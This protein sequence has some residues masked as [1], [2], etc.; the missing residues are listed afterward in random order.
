MVIRRVVQFLLPTGP[1]ALGRTVAIDGAGESIEVRPDTEADR[2]EE[3]TDRPRLRMF[4]FLSGLTAVVAFSVDRFTNYGW[5]EHAMDMVSRADEIASPARRYLETRVPGISPADV[6]VGCMNT[7]AGWPAC[8]YV[9][10]TMLPYYAKS[11][12]P[13]KDPPPYSYLIFVGDPR[14]AERPDAQASHIRNF[15]IEVPLTREAF[16]LVRRNP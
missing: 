16:L 3:L 14:V 13:S 7:D 4:V 12:P 6:S 10:C 2:V 9:W 1:R 15:R 8:D 5:S 11:T